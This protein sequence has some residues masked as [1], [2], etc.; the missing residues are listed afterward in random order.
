VALIQFGRDR[1]AAFEGCRIVVLDRQ[2]LVGK[3]GYI[4]SRVC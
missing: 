1:E 4:V 2:I 3:I